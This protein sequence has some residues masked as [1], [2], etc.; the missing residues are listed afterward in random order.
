[1][2]DSYQ[3]FSKKQITK[4]TDFKGLKVGSAGLNLRWLQGFGAA[5]V[6]GSLVTYYNKLKT[7]VLDA[8]MLWPESVAGRKIYEVAPY[9]LKAD[10]GAVN[11]KAITVNTNTWKRLP[12]EVR[13]VLQESAIAYRDRVAK[14]AL[15]KAARSIAKIKAN[16]GTIFVMSQAG[17]KKWANTMPNVAKF[18]AD[19]LE[20]KGLPGKA[21]LASYMDTMRAA[22]QPIIR[23][24]DKE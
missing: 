9:M 15:A 7:G 12:G 17:R 4:L 6:G 2:L 24:C 19:S 20:K 8:I 18:W 1:V 13:K 5:G 14:Q 11:S 16:G 23:H 22:G 21:I 3:I 10:L